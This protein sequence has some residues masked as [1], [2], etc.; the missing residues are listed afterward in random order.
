MERKIVCD[1]AVVGGGT[2]GF[3]AAVGAARSGAKTVLLERGAYL[4]GQATHSSVAAFCGL[5]SRGNPP[6][7]IVAGVGE[8]L[9]QQLRDLGEDTTC[10]VSPTTGNT[11]V[12]F[13]PEMLKL[14][15]DL[16]V[17]QFGVELLL[18]AVLIDAQIEDGRVRS[19]ECADDS[20]R[21]TVEAKAF[22]DA[23]GDANLA[24]LAGCE[25]LWGNEKGVVQQAGLV[26]R[27]DRISADT[28]TTPGEMAKAIVK[29]REAGIAPLPKD[30]G[31]MIRVDGA[32]IGYCTAPSVTI[33]SLDSRTLTDAEVTLRR[34]AHAYV[35]AFQQY[36]PGMEESRMVMTG[37]QMGLRESR[38]IAG[39]V[40]LTAQDVLAVRKRPDTIAR[41][42]WSPEVH[43]ENDV[44]Y[45]HLHD[46]AWFDIPIGAI[47]VKNMANLWCA[48][49]NISCDSMA[50][51]SVRVMGTALATGHGA[52]VAAALTLDREQYDYR[53]IQ[54]ELERQ[55]ALLTQK[56]GQT[57]SIQ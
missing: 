33:S 57:N 35:K 40:M 43:K 17:E 24:F 48:G 7:Q 54:D 15:M 10:W 29:A 11:S 52:G 27:I 55:G 6:V 18:H 16:V 12:R 36:M 4:G 9:L 26:A 2:A 30:N 14:A 23:T 45:T 1:V 28:D 49:R 42:G 46:A 13:Q 51:A 44:S 20:G 3:A 25:T 37:P 53:A 50:H 39:E 22:V 32:D 31:F 21:F 47:K 19:I 38:R 34:Q 8:I 56:D 41:G 5:Y